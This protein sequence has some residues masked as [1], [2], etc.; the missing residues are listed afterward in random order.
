MILYL[1]LIIPILGSLLIAILPNSNEEVWK[2]ENAKTNQSVWIT[3]IERRIKK[4]R[5]SQG[6]KD[7]GNENVYKKSEI[8]EKNGRNLR[9]ENVKNPQEDRFL[10]IKWIA[11]IT[12]LINFILSLLLLVDYNQGII[13]YQNIGD[14][15][16]TTNWEIIPKGFLLSEYKGPSI[17]IGIDGLSIFFVLLTTTITPICILSSWK[18]IKIHVKFFL[19]CFLN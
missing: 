19:I 10:R 16:N 4:W 12:S 18:E 14:L 15:L 3:D 1:V 6:E 13:F 8:S 7:L 11:L 2:S 9:E 5:Q 17:Y